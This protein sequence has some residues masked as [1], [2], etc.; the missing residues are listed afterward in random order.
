MQTGL[1][2]TALFGNKTATK[3]V[4][5]A[6]APAKTQ[7]K[8]VQKQVKK[9]K[10][11]TQ[12]I[13]RAQ[14]PIRKAAPKPGRQSNED[15]LW[16]PN[17]DRPAWLDGSMPGDRGFDPLGLAAPKEYLQ[18][19]VDQLDQNVAV[20]KAGNIVGKFS[21]VKQDNNSLAPYDDVFG[22]ARFRETELIHGRQAVVSPTISPNLDAVYTSCKSSRWAMLATLGVL[23][24]EASTG[25]SW[26]DAGKVELDGAQYLGF[27]LPFTITQ[28]VWIEAILVGGAEVYRNRERGLFDPLGLASEN[29]DKAFRLKTAEIKHGRLAMIAF[30]GFGIQA[31]VTG[32]GA[33]GS[34]AQFSNS[35]GLDLEGEFE[36]IERAV[37]GGVQAAENAI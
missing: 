4:K 1:K 25:V 37:E 5:K 9:A 32:Q 20:N 27:R 12:T 36:S 30:L 26:V 6:A 14:A 17:A 28:L 22:L 23:I 2:T 7:V 29:D 19:D 16:L 13:K 15:S 10:P 8:K 18:Y 35:F 31:L 3:Q 11:G 24:G 21:G 34:L 33:L